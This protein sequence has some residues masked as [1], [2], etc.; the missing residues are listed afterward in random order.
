MAAMESSAAETSDP[1]ELGRDPAELGRILAFTDGVFAIA[2]T[3]LVLNFDVPRLPGGKEWELARAL[4]QVGGDIAVY[5]F[6]FAVVGRLWIVHHDLFATLRTLDPRLMAL[7]LGYLSMIV[8]VPFAAQMVGDYGDQPLAA[9]VYG[10]VLGLAALLNW[11]M[12]RYAAARGFARPERRDRVESRASPRALY[13]PILFLLSV[14]VAF[15]SPFAAEAMWL[16]LVLSRL[17]GGTR[18]SGGRA[19]LGGSAGR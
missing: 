5:F 10:A 16:A 12:A 13:I 9:G 8:L 17:A 18:H 11:V 15:L 4:E 6:T 3:L 7:N 14:P 1:A 2:I 19:G